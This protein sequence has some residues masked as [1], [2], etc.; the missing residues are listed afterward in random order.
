MN[1]KNLKT[2][3]CNAIE[4]TEK[5]ERDKTNIKKVKALAN[6]NHYSSLKILLAIL[7]AVILIAAAHSGSHPTRLVNKERISGK[8]VVKIMR[9]IFLLSTSV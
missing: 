3:L 7:L 8:S 6:F 2:T 9:K 4:K 5:L 1:R